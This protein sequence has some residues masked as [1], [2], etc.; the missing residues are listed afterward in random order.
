MLEFERATGIP[1]RRLTSMRQQITSGN[2]PLRND[3]VE[4]LMLL[5]VAVDGRLSTCSPELLGVPSMEYGDFVLGHVLD[6]GVR[7]DRWPGTF[8]RFVT[9]VAAGRELC[10]A[11]CDYYALCGGGAAANKL[12]ENGTVVST[13]T[14]AC[15]CNIQSVVDVVLEGLERDRAATG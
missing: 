13:E 15:I 11:T 3:Q 14:S 4:P 12:V 7:L 5:S 1:V 2:L 9:D 6:P 10:A 8:E